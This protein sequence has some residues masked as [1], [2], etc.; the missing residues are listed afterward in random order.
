MTTDSEPAVEP[1][2]DA[3]AEIDPELAALI[4][5]GQ[6]VLSHA[7]MVRTFIKHSEETEDFPELMIAARV[8]F[9]LSLALGARTE[10]PPAYFKMLRKKIG[11]LRKAA[12]SFAADAPLASTHT[13][14]EQAVQ[15]LYVCVGDFES[16]LER[17]RARLKELE[18]AAD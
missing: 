16:L 15:S 9:D 6:D 12:D 17:G 4:A 13:N 2:A 18:P 11:K 10:D 7:W 5:R 14:F 8:V 1:M 3:P